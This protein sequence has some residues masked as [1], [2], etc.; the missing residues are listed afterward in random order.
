MRSWKIQNVF[1]KEKANSQQKKTRCF[2]ALYFTTSLILFFLSCD[3]TLLGQNGKG[4]EKKLPVPSGNPKQLFYLQRSKN[5]NTVVYELNE[6]N[7]VL[8]TENPIH[9]SWILYEKQERRE[10]LSTMENRFAYGIK[11]TSSTKESYEFTL[12]AYPKISLQ[13][14][15]GADQKYHVYISPSRQQIILQK[16][17]IKVIPGGFQLGPNVEYIEFS[18]I[19]VVSGKE[20]TERITP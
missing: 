20:V 9:I 19:D 8:N 2:T 10:E 7:G 6:Q 16:A 14:M 3:L 4:D 12:V 15:K 1:L 11:I 17:Y 5:T 13:L 18:G